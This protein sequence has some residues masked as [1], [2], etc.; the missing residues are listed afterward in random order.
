MPQ[1]QHPSQADSHSV[2]PHPH[3]VTEHSLR[4][5]QANIVRQ[6]RATC[7]AIADLDD[8]RRAESRARTDLARVISDASELL[9]E[10]QR[11]QFR[12]LFADSVPAEAERCGYAS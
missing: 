3:R 5:K 4:M 11:A 7:R 8:A 9:T 2:A 12:A 10:D 6:I 1:P